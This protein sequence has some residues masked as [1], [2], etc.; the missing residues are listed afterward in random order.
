MR[1]LCQCQG[2]DADIT[3]RPPGRLPQML[4]QDDTDGRISA[5]AAI[6]VCHLPCQ[7]PA[8]QAIL[9]PILGLTLLCFW[10]QVCVRI[11]F[12]TKILNLGEIVKLI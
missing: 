9:Q 11:K 3:L 4:R 7:D 5:P 8:A 6:A 2:D 1:H 10:V 12:C